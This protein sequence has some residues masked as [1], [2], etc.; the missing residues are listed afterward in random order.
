MFTWRQR[1]NDHTTDNM[2]LKS[3]S[4][5]RL[6]PELRSVPSFLQPQHLD[7]PISPSADRIR[8]LHSM[9][10]ERMVFLDIETPALNILKQ[11]PVATVV[12]AL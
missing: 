1:A 8:P 12:A 5:R 11:V 6:E 4:A 10:G 2:K 7:N 3:K 9:P